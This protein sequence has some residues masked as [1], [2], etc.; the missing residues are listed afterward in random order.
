M[1]TYKTLPVNEQQKAFLARYG[2]YYTLITIGIILA[3]LLSAF[4]ESGM[5]YTNARD[6]TTVF[7]DKTANILGI[8]AAIVGV[9]LIEIVGIRVALSGAVDS[10]L[11]KRFKGLDALFSIAF[12]ILT[13]ALV[14]ASFIL[15]LRGGS[16]I[17]ESLKD[18]TEQK[19]TGEI[20]ANESTELA[21]LDTTYTRNIAAVKETYKGLIDSEIQKAESDRIVKRQNYKHWKSKGSRYK[22]KINNALMELQG[23]EATKTANIAQ[24]KQQQAAE[25]KEL[26]TRYDRDKGAIKNEANTE[27]TATTGKIDSKSSAF[28]TGTKWIVI[29][30]M[31]F[32]VGFTVMQRIF[33]KGS[34]IEELAEPNNFFFSPSLLSERIKLLQDKVQ[35]SKRNKI[36]AKREGLSR[37]TPYASSLPI[38][39]VGNL[40][41][42]IL[43]LQMTNGEQT[44]VYYLDTKQLEAIQQLP[45]AQ[46]DISN[47]DL[48]NRITSLTQAQIAAESEN[49]HEAAKVVELQA[50]EVIKLYLKRNGQ[51]TNEEEITAFQQRVIDH[52]NEPKNC[53]NPFD[54]EQ[55]RTI[56]FKSNNGNK[57][58]TNDDRI[59][60]ERIEGKTNEEIN[61]E[62]AK[63]CAYS[64]CSN[65]L[66]GKH[67]NQ[68]YCSDNCRIKAW[69]DRNGR[70]L[71]KKPKK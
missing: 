49:H 65:T 5:L 31:F 45:Q 13:L 70:S 41:R 55:K 2:K 24:L 44:Q 66:K 38:H 40:Q 64:K 69:E 19:K 15:S 3:Q 39:D 21:K 54:N 53:A 58:E 67:W 18:K 11:Y 29:I 17:V 16:Q 26:E 8:V 34:G 63:I 10:L 46:L 47:E 22:T 25:L 50:K 7:G 37:L 12:I 62:D 20:E 51:N 35:I 6:A 43:Q 23:V 36:A 28:K 60:G 68:K 59:Y 27:I 14:P 30:A 32:A 57:N 1:Q 52:L 71:K 42:S 56:G 4:T 48:E 61:N 33:L 9:A